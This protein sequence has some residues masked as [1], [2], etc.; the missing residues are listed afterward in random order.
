MSTPTNKKTVPVDTIE[1]VRQFEATRREMM[2]FMEKHSKTFEQMRALANEYNQTLE[3][4]EKAV[5]AK[6]VNCGPFQI[7]SIATTYDVDSLFEEIGPKEFARL[8]GGQETVVK[9]TMDKAT[10]EAAIVR[11]DIPEEIADKVKQV[12]ARYKRIPP[13]SLP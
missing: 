2:A 8:G 7:L 5:K 6:G 4:A 10:I 9:H 11:R 13:V 1:E 3:A 12:Q